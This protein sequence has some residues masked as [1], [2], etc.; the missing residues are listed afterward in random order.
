MLINFPVTKFSEKLFKRSLLFESSNC[1]DPRGDSVW[2]RGQLGDDQIQGGFFEKPSIAIIGTRYPTSYGV[3]FVRDFLDAWVQL[4]PQGIRDDI[5]I[6]S[7]GAHGID[8]EV[9]KACLQRR[10]PTW[11]W[12]VGPILYPNPR[13]QRAIFSSLERQPHSGLL[14]PFVLEPPPRGLAASRPLRSYWLER[15]RWLVASVDAVVVVE[16]NEK[17]GTWSSVRVAQEFGIP[18][19]ALGGPYN[20]RQSGGTN[21]MIS[22]GYAHPILSVGKLVESLVVEMRASPYNKGRGIDQ[23]KSSLSL[24]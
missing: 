14:T 21:Q 10:L 8:L 11:A 1:F 23:I 20:S 9:H 15:N 17:S 3:G 18:V 24:C 5:L 19:F 7:G 12:V 16:A 4:I 13:S 2:M 6:F 22:S